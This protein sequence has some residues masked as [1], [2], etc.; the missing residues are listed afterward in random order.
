MQI[1]V[2]KNGM[3]RNIVFFNLA[4]DLKSSLAQCGLENLEMGK[5]YIT[6]R[7]R[8]DGT[9]IDSALDYI[10]V[11]HDQNT[12]ITAKKMDASSTDYLPIIAEVNFKVQEAKN[13]KNNP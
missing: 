1:C 3:K 5:T 4:A 11:S 13:K 9:V 12:K 2:P 7:L 10:Y 8:N 6:D